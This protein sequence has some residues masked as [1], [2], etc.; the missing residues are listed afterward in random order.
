MMSEDEEQRQ[1]EAE[2][3]ELASMCIAAMNRK[4]PTDPIVYQNTKREK[5]SFETKYLKNDEA[6]P[7]KS[8]NPRQ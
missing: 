8:K 5:T 4:R 2:I 6:R 1:F 7:Q 3:E